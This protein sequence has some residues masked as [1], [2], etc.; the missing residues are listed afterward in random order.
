M[1]QLIVCRNVEAFESTHGLL[2]PE[3]LVLGVVE[4]PSFCRGLVAPSIL[5]A[6]GVEN[7]LK[8]LGGSGRGISGIIGYRPSNRESPQAAPPD[9]KW[10]E[11]LEEIRIVKAGPSITDPGRFRFDVEAGSDVGSLIPIIAR[12]IRG[13]AYQPSAPPLIAFEEEHRLLAVSPK[14]LAFSRMDDLLDFWIM[15][16][17]MVDLIVDAW[18]HKDLVSPDRQ[19]RQGI[20]SIEIFKRLPATDCR[21]CGSETCMEFANSLLMGRGKVEECLPIS[22]EINADQLSSLL[23]LLEAIG[24]DGKPRAPRIAESRG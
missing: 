3:G 11:A 2:R 21:Q 23:W 17:T 6:R 18:E 7:R 15:L 8:E 9:P 14:S 12:M 13:G 1:A 16:R 10:K 22:E 24:L 20:G 5:I 4:P 19:P